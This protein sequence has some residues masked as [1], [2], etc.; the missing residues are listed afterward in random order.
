M[1]LNGLLD[2][3]L[4]VVT[5]AQLLTSGLSQDAL[6]H[7]LRAGG[8]WQMLLPGVYLTASGTPTLLQKEVAALLYGGSGSILTGPLALFH[9]GVRGLDLETIDVL[10]PA[11]RKR[12]ST[13]FVRMHRTTRM[14]GRIWTAG[15]IRFA[16]TAR[17]V[18]DTVR[19]LPSAR[20]V[21]ALTADAVQQGKCAL[22][23]LGLELAEGSSRQSA[24]FRSVLAEVA[25]GI[26]STVE[27]DLRGLIRVARVPTPLYN[28]SVYDGAEF[29]GRPDAWWPEAGVAAEADSRAWHLSPEGWEKTMTRHDRMAAA[30]IIVLHFS[31]G[32]LRREKD[33]VIAAIKSALE[34]GRQRSPLGL[35][36]VP[37]DS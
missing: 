4:G 10:I 25:D 3:Q 12:T 37:M 35:R 34:R 26:Q 23:E 24:V 31:P 33:K 6:R 1:N 8:P 19:Q 9:H 11:A 18:S 21:R 22:S 27:G 32:Q 20:D 2:P 16:A 30:G 7:R 17:A 36:T 5:R 29:L 13:R 15:P 14:P 28:A